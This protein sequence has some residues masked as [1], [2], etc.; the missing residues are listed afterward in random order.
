MYWDQFL[1]GVSYFKSL[2]SLKMFFNYLQYV[3]SIRFNL[4]F[5]MTLGS[6]KEIGINY[7]E[8]WLSNNEYWSTLSH[9]TKVERNR[10][11][12]KH[13]LRYLFRPLTTYVCTRETAAFGG[14]SL[15][16][17]EWEVTVNYVQTHRCSDTQTFGHT[18][19]RTDRRSDTQTF[20]H[21]DVRTHRCS[22]TQ[23]DNNIK[24]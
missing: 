16:L 19:V 18:D 15:A 13:I 21:T 23:T 22:D 10:V 5:L 7:V 8:N 17:R 14:V 9:L 20:G 6:T 11:F 12:T 4:T 24:L 1:I 3:W 2:L